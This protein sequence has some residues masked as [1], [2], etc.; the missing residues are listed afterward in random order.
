[1]AVKALIQAD[2]RQCRHMILSLGLKAMCYTIYLSTD[3]PADLCV[4]NTELVRFDICDNKID[5]PVVKL[6]EFP[7]RWYV[8]SKSECSCTF[9][10][11]L[12]VDLGFGEPVDW[13]PE[14][15][16]ALQATRELYEVISSLLSSG[17]KVD[18]IDKWEGAEPN[19]IQTLDVSLDDV[20]SKTFRLFENH[21]FRI[22]K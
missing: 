17:Y 9:R 14:E 2:G 20:S 8:G 13:Y 19:D 11:L 4:H 3:S 1:M 16:D 6:L 21:R 5:D 22:K 7:Q 15:Q 10:H 12:S 18:C